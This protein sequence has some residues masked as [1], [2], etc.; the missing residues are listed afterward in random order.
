M[1]QRARRRA[2]AAA[3]AVVSLI[4]LVQA[5][6]HHAFSIDRHR[7]AHGESERTRAVANELTRFAH[8]H[9]GILAPAAPPPTDLFETASTMAGLGP[10]AMTSLDSR[11]GRQDDNGLVP[12]VTT[13]EIESAS[14]R[15]VLEFVLYV[16]ESDPYTELTSIT[17][18]V[19][20]SGRDWDA[21]LG[22]ERQGV[23]DTG[24]A[25]VDRVADR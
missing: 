15:S 22:F 9:A 2:L 25:G 11:A 7:R 10:R 18:Q 20:E 4:V 1:T 14:L 3:A 23:R 12:I 19:G 13:T 24:Q 16:R 21:T 5:M 17:L 8:E 6:G